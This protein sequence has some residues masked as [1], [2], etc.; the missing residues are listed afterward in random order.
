MIDVLSKEKVLA[1]D[2]ITI[3]KISCKFIKLGPS[4]AWSRDHEAMGTDVC[5]IRREEDKVEVIPGVC[6]LL[7]LKCCTLTRE[8]NRS[9]SSTRSTYSTSL[10]VLELYLGK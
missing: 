4:S 8:S 3:D 2:V 10:L 6:I 9:S 5:C 1:G 7:R